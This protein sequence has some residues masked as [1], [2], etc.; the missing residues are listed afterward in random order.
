T[1]QQLPEAAIVE[2]MGG[3]IHLLP[4][5]PDRS[6]TRIIERIGALTS[7]IGG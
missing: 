3:E 4:F 7:E 2:S 5:L 1:R 6:T